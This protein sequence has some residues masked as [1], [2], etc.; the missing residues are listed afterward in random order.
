MADLPEMHKNVLSLIG[1]GKERATTSSYISKL[2]GLND[3][4]VRSIISELNTKY[5]I[6][7][8]S[9]LTGFYYVTNE[10]ERR[11]CLLN[12]RGRAAKINYRA[13]VMELSPL[14]NPEN[15]IF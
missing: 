8:G 4:D 5:R 6:L 15:F 13:D 3:V 10:D 14:V 1:F 11:E 2:T 7:I 9:G 12:L